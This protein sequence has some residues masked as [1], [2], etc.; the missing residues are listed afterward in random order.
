M[1]DPIFGPQF[2]LV[3]RPEVVANGMQWREVRLLYVRAQELIPEIQDAQEQFTKAVKA[4]HDAQK[5]QQVAN[6]EIQQVERF[7]VVT[8]AHQRT[9][10]AAEEEIERQAG[11][12][13]DLN[14]QIE[15]HRQRY[16][17]LTRELRQDF[18]PVLTDPELVRFDLPKVD[19]IMRADGVLV[20]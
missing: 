10:L 3:P 9:I 8:D 14:T 20:N 1:T 17:S 12:I 6:R 16:V 7:G 19:D 18:Q 4:R 2:A 11:I 13:G 15:T 5:T